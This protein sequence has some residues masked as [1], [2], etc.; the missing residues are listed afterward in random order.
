MLQ[1]HLKI[2]QDILS[3]NNLPQLPTWES[4]ITDSTVAPFSDR[5]ML[6][7]MMLLTEIISVN[8]GTALSSMM[9][10]DLG[11]HFMRLRAE[12]LKYGEDTL[13]LM[14]ENEYL[15]ELPMAKKNDQ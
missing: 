3:E 14:I 6:F 15:D 4:E 12:L 2:F 9:R 11:L 8:Y 1:K 5:L 13:N 7:K 10:R